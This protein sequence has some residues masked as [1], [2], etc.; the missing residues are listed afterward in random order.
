MDIRPDPRIVRAE[1]WRC[2]LAMAN[3]LR[4]GAISY[5][6]RDYVVLRLTTEDG[7]IGH[8][9]GY[10]RNT[11]LFEATTM[12]CEQL[13]DLPRDPEQAHRILRHRFAPG[14]AALTRAAS[15][16]DI[17]LWDLRAQEDDVLLARALGFEPRPVPMMAVAGYFSDLRTID[18]QLAEMERFVADGF[19]TLK[20]ILPGADARADQ[21]T[22]ERV[23]D[24]FPDEVAV[25]VDFH[26]AFESVEAAVTHC[27]GI[28]ELGVRFIEDPFPS[29]D[30]HR[31]AAFAAA[32]PTP[33]AAGEDLTSLTGIEDL[34]DNGVRYLRAD[35]T[36]S[37]GFTVARRALT[38][39]AL[40]GAAVAPHVWPHVHVHLA[41]GALA[42]TSIEAIPD[43]VGADP[44]WSLLSEGA[45]IRDGLWHPPSTPG[46]GMP[47]DVDAVRAHA[48][49][50]SDLAVPVPS[51]AG[52][53]TNAAAVQGR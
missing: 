40:R 42:G 27:A 37:G 52:Q 38:H 15:L 19:T 16:I 32:S 26:G 29:A 4:L 53:R 17:A 49:R 39:A 34:L 1:V 24:H 13:S 35:A 3:T 21:A 47:L 33:V 6:T 22:L 5:R 23:R 28:H 43:Y 48:D 36:A 8:G 41:A 18:Q 12:L 14:W 44:V 9:I 10:T 25:G 46:L 51:G 50:S 11:P 2:P 45:P 30:W 31:V 7:L 20:L